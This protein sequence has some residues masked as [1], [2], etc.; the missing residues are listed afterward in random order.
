MCRFTSSGLAATIGALWMVTAS[1][2]AIA[3]D[4][5]GPGDRSA[6]SVASPA[7]VQ[8]WKT[9]E[10]G[11]RR[12]VNAYREALDAAAVRVGEAANEILG[13]PAF[14][15]VGAKEKVEL[16]IRSVA[17]LGV[18]GESASLA[19][20]YGRA[21]R[22][23][24]A[25]CPPEAGPQLRLDYADQPLGEILHVAT[26]PVATYAGDLTILALANAGT[27]LLL[28]GSD[29]RPDFMAPRTLRFVFAVPQAGPAVQARRD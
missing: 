9:I 11:A 13:R 5:R 28:I 19:E 17:D 29:G 27:G 18:V 14:R 2:D 21:R 26:E 1:T 4:N 22:L 10:I 6:A 16:V 23:G 25:L 7:A 8:A 3:Q 15:Y 20:I 12:S 24:L